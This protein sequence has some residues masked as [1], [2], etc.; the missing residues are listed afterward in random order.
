[1]TALGPDGLPRTV[2][3]GTDPYATDPLA[4]PAWVEAGVQAFLGIPLI[5]GDQVIGAM[6]LFM[7]Q[8]GKT[9]GK[10]PLA[11]AEGIARMAAIAVSNARL[12]SEASR[13]AEEAQA[14]IR[15]ARSITA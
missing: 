2:P 10:E 7:R 5:A 4:L 1:M 13:R 8:R 6:G 9:F 11:I 12:Y 14:L 3:P 15:T